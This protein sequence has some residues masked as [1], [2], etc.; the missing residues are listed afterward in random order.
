MELGSAVDAS[1]AQSIGEPGTEMTLKTFHFAGV[2]YMNITLGVPLI[3]N[4]IHTSKAIRLAT[5]ESGPAHDW[6]SSYERPSSTLHS[7]NG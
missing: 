7:T 2:A 5:R 6:D 4:I 1:C 3:K